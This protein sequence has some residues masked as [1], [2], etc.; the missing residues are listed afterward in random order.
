M[1]GTV[2]ALSYGLLKI[3][4]KDENGKPVTDFEK[5]IVYDGGTELKEWVALANYLASFEP[6]DGIS[7]IPEYYNRLHGRKVEETSRSPAALLKS[8]NKIFFILLGTIILILAII[9]V[10]ACLVIRKVR[11]KKAR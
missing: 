9:I 2:E 4:P 11:R 7:K 5:H 8:P 6:A 3:T 10:P 1:L